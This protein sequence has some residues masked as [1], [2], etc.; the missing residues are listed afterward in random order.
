M[1]E[2][3][4]DKRKLQQIETLINIDE[5][6][7]EAEAED[8][9]KGLY[10]RLLNKKIELHNNKID[11]KDNKE[12]LKT[13]EIDSVEFY[14]AVKL[15]KSKKENAKLISGELIEEYQDKIK[16]ENKVEENKKYEENSKMVLTLLERE[17]E[18]NEN[19]KD[20]EAQCGA[21][22]VDKKA[23]E[24]LITEKMKELVPKKKQPEKNVVLENTVESYSKILKERK[25]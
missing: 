20:L 25:K 21:L 15:N 16:N 22:G 23:M 18:I 11:I 14:Q 1:S 19:Y 2:K 4:E 8:K 5:L 10:E 12:D 17:E 7:P 9:V 3:T 24:I 13:N 6:F